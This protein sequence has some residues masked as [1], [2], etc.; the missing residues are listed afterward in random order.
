MAA[1]L[2]D[3]YFNAGSFAVALGKVINLPLKRLWQISGRS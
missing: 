2:P 3:E 1:E